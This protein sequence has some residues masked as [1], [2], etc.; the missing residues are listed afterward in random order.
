MPNTVETKSNCENSHNTTIFID[1]KQM[2]A[3]M[4]ILSMTLSQYFAS[5][6]ASSEEI[7]S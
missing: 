2:L 3:F 7:R 4:N 6:H 5:L 1:L